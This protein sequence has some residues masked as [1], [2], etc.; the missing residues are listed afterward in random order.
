M[1]IRIIVIYIIQVMS[2]TE[3]SNNQNTKYAKENT[4]IYLF[5]YLFICVLLNYMPQMTGQL[6]DN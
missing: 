6:A 5:I 1:E 3:Y 4:V 2:P